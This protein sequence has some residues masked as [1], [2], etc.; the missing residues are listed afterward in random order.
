MNGLSKFQFS[1]M[2]CCIACFAAVMRFTCASTG[3]SLLLLLAVLMVSGED[4]E[5]AGT[6]LIQAPY[7]SRSLALLN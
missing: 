5:H 6:L 4:G 2:V 3:V 7:P 1:A